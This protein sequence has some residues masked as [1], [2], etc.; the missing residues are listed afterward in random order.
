MSLNSLRLRNAVMSLSPLRSL[1]WTFGIFFAGMLVA[2]IRPDIDYSVAS[3]AFLASCIAAAFAATASTRSSIPVNLP[4]LASSADR[5]DWRRASQRCVRLAVA[6][7]LLLAIDRYALRGVPIGSDAFEA[8]DALKDSSSG[9]VGTLAAFLSSFAAFGWISTWIADFHGQPPSRRQR[10]LAVASLICYVAMSLTL[11]SRSLLLVCITLHAYA[12]LFLRQ[13]RGTAFNK[14]IIFALAV[15]AMTIVAT[16]AYILQERL[17]LMG[18]SM[19]DS[20]QLSSYAY[21]LKPTDAVLQF[22]SKNDF[23][24]SFGAAVYSLILYLYH[25]TYEFFLLFDSYNGPSTLGTQTLWLPLKLLSIITGS[26]APDNIEDTY[27]GYRSGVFTTFAG[28]FYVDFN[29]FSPLLIWIVYRALSTPFSRLAGGD[30]RW[31]FATAQVA[32]IVAFSPMM[33]LLQS[34]TGTYLLIAA[35]AMVRLVPAKQPGRIEA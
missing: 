4:L 15:A 20:I 16:L 2:P 28:P 18:L 17:A 3:V 21:T 14:Y 13:A 30:L 10:L 5:L 34:A 19:I 33:N 11:G 1:T 6:G 27:D 29:L 35:V 32:V 23:L 12:S 25:G 22:L 26:A 8:R 24:E 7:V 9:L 31:Y